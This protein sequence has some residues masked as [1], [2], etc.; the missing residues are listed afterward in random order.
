MTH[1]PDL[2]ERI[3][4][5]DERIATLKQQ[6]ADAE[7]ERDDLN[8]LPDWWEEYQWAMK[9][10]NGHLG[11]PWTS[12]LPIERKFWKGFVSRLRARFSPPP[13]ND[14][15]SLHNQQVRIINDQI[16]K[17][18]TLH[19]HVK[20]SLEFLGC[21]IS[22]KNG[23]IPDSW[24]LREQCKIAGQKLRAA[25]GGKPRDADALAEKIF[26]ATDAQPVCFVCGSS[27]LPHSASGGQCDACRRVYPT[28]F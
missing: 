9:E 7:A 25:T 14:D 8:S 23:Y 18:K 3:A 4:T 11:N 21:D 19:Q 10:S 6:L 26:K 2:D 27:Y 22:V 5:L 17:L 12:L 28:Q 1:P 13:A 20:E 16:E 24:T 15:Y